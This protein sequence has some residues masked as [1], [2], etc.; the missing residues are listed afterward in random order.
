MR[1]NKWFPT[2]I[3]RSQVIENLMLVL[4]RLSASE[5]SQILSESHTIT[6]DKSNYDWTWQ[7]QHES[8][9]TVT[10]T[11]QIEQCTTAKCEEESCCTEYASVLPMYIYTYSK[12]MTTYKTLYTALS[13]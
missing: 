10:I 5:S 1:A 8:S 6:M 12:Y 2:F 11:L 7:Y 3:V 9:T 13:H 4:N